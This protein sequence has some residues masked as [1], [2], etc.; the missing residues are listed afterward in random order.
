M[1]GL[2][3]ALAITAGLGGGIAVAR[4]TDPEPEALIKAAMV[5]NFTKVVEWRVAARPDSQDF[6]VGVV[7]EGPTATALRGIAGRPVGHATLR[8][9]VVGDAESMRGCQLVFFGRSRGDSLRFFLHALGGA[10]VLTV[11]DADHF[12][13]YGGVLQLTR[14]QNRVHILVNPKAA[15]RAQLKISSQLLKIAEIVAEKDGHGASD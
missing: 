1:S 6:V 8:V 5:Y 11:S 13:E 3:L 9:R 12:T 14:S 2:S 7:G 4:A 15:E 10:A